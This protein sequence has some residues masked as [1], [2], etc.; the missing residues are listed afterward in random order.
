[1]KIGQ[2]LATVSAQVEKCWKTRQKLDQKQNQRVFGHLGWMKLHPIVDT[3]LPFT[4]YGL[5]YS[6]NSQAL[7]GKIERNC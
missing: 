7:L 1:M 3:H 6:R 4:P 5:S 2:K